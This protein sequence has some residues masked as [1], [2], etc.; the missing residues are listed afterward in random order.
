MTFSLSIE[1]E[2]GHYGE[3][4]NMTCGWC[5]KGNKACNRYTGHCLSGCQEGYEGSTCAEG[6]EM[7]NF[8]RR[9]NEFRY[10]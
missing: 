9:F 3:N 8:A 4:C 6:K 10:I 5:V 2:D 1:C 7:Q